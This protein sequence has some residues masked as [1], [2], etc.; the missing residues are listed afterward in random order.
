MKLSRLSFINF[1]IRS[2]YVTPI[3]EDSKLTKKIFLSKYVLVLDISLRVSL[4]VGNSVAGGKF[5]RKFS[6]T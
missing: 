4:V 5:C 6:H 3:F 2:V 1:S